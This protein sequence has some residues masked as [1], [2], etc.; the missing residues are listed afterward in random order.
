MFGADQSLNGVLPCP[1]IDAGIAASD[2]GFGDLKIDRRLA[3]GVVF[4]FDDLLRCI[5][6]RGGETGALSGPGIDAVK[7]S[8]PDAPTN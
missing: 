5:L 1:G 7:S 8:T 3:L 4:R 2:V 6:A